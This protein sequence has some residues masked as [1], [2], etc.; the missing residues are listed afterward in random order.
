MLHNHSK[1]ILFIILT[2]SLPGCVGPTTK[3]IDPNDASVEIEAEKQREIALRELF[4][5]HE[6]VQN[7]GWPLLKAGMPLCK[8]RKTW[9]PGFSAINKH[10]FSD[11]MRDTAVSL[12][13]LTDVLQV[14]FVN[15]SSPAQT[16]G[17]QKG[18][19]LMEVNGKEAPVGKDAVTKLHDLIKEESKDGK[20]LSLKV[21]R[22]GI[23]EIVNITPE[24]TCDYP[25]IIVDDTA[26]NAYADGNIIAINQGMMDFATTDDELSLVIGHELAHNSMRHINARRINA[27]GGFLLDILAAAAGI[28]TQGAFTQAAANAYSQEFEAEADYVGLYIVARAGREISEAPYFW[29]RMG[30]KYPGSINKNYTASHPSSPE[31]FVAI[32]ETI[33]EIDSKKS[34]DEPLMPNLDDKKIEEREPPP[35]V[36]L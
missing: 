34:A 30:V 21:K 13:G 25:L 17:L 24:E 14:I 29:R 1:T 10:A 31:R 35:T 22:N 20:D 27:L 8:D 5:S 7:V 15:D 19:L 33:K 12:Y 36:K 18:D 32:E 3:T 11:E 16:A 6:R 2:L 9:S 4:K 26:V 23:N 28:N